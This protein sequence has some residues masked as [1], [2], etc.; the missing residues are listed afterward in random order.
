MT[1]WTVSRMDITGIQP[2]SLFLPQTSDMLYVMCHVISCVMLHV[3]LGIIVH[4][5]F[6]VTLPVM[7]HPPQC[8]AYCHREAL[9]V[10][11]LKRN[12]AFPMLRLSLFTNT[13]TG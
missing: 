2:P 3:M 4:F 7:T 6:H 11:S 13:I 9:L 8:T 10:S 5:M 12:H 1:V